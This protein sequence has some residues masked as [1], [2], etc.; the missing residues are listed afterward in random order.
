MWMFTH[1]VL[2]NA[3]IKKFSLLSPMEGFFLKSLDLS[4]ISWPENWNI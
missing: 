1:G 4:V 2:L 3:L